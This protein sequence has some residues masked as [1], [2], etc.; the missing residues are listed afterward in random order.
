MAEINDLIKRIDA[1]FN[2]SQEKL[3]ASQ[4]EQIQQHVDRR[5]RLEQFA[6]LC[7]DLA[8]VWRPRLEALKAKFGDHVHV[9]PKIEP[10]RRS[11]H[12]RFDTEVARVDLRFAACAD[13]DARN[14]IVTCDLDVLPILMKIDSHAEIQFPLE[15]VDRDA[16]AGWIDDRIVGFV[17]TYLSLHE[18]AYYLK[19]HMVED[20]VAKVQF[21]KFAAGATLVRAGKTHYFIDESTRDE[22]EKQH[23]V[24][25]Q[26]AMR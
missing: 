23:A 20:P 8:G 19:G 1:A 21:P 10:N 24:A 6:A 5:Q 15:S 16:L 17:Q 26:P 25:P 9:E 14:V 12:F 4:K 11:A 3:R 7:E 18:N 22:F 2:S 13:A